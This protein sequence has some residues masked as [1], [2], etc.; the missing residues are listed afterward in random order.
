MRNPQLLI[1]DGM[2]HNRVIT[3][4]EAY[5]CWKLVRRR[6]TAEEALKIIRERQARKAQ[7]KAEKARK[8]MKTPVLPKPTLEQLIARQERLVD[9]IIMANQFC[10]EWADLD[11]PINPEDA[12]N[13]VSGKVRTEE[14]FDED[15]CYS[16][17]NGSESLFR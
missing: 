16:N 14:K 7:R 10:F 12:M 11:A 6:V 4:S 9:L 8:M 1:V 17:T 3:L 5:K 2:L 13:Y 15:Y